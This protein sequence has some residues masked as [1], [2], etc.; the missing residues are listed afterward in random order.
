MTWEILKIS[1]TKG[2][3]IGKYGARVINN[4]VQLPE[5]FTGKTFN[6]YLD[7]KNLIAK[8]VFEKAGMR[9]AG[10]YLSIPI[11]VKE[12]FKEEMAVVF[13]EE[14]VIYLGKYSKGQEY[15]EKFI[16]K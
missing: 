2:L 11:A 13:P 7:R 1:G 15:L 3:H 5:T 12:L 9:T 4:A 6:W 14:N 10:K 8:V 16:E